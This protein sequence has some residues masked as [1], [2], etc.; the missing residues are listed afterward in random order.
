M[1][2]GLKRMYW[3]VGMKKEVDQYVAACLICQKAKI[4]HQK[5]AG[6]L[7]PLNIPSCCFIYWVFVDMKMP[8]RKVWLGLCWFTEHARH[9]LAGFTLRVST[10]C[11]HN[12]F[13][14]DADM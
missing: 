8:K 7:Q 13:G 4:D 1:Y 14:S 5:L 12:L 6:M 10:N 2:Q 9:D 3:W 11:L